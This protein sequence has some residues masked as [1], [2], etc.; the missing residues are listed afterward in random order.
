MNYQTE[1][2]IKNIKEA[3]KNKEVLKEIDKKYFGS[4]KKKKDFFTKNKEHFTADELVYLEFSEAGEK[5]EV[6]TV[7]N[8]E[9]EE[10]NEPTNQLTNLE[11]NFFKDKD[12]LKALIEI[13]QKYRSKSENVEI[14]EN[15]IITIPAEAKLKLDRNMAVKVNGELYD[16]IVEMSYKNKVGKGELVTYILW[17]FYKKHN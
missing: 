10:T 4:N 1:L 17:E 8:R 3:I 9:V 16:K 6:K 5:E 14:I 2:K 12:N 11:A 7:E 15:G 13:V